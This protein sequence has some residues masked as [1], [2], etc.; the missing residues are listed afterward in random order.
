VECNI[1]LEGRQQSTRF[2]LGD[3]KQFD[4]I[5]SLSDYAIVGGLQE[6]AKKT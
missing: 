5:F 6:L 3:N 1:P 4:A 2:L